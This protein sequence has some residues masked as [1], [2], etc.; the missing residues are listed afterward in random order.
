MTD[1][2]GKAVTSGATLGIVVSNVDTEFVLR[3]EEQV[4]AW[5]QPGPHRP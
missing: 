5:W 1:E 3:M 2:D 4:R